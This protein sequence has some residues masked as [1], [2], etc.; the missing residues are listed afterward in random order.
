LKRGLI[1]SRRASSQT[2]QATVAADYPA[3]PWRCERTSKI[4]F[5]DGSIEPSLSRMEFATLQGIKP[6]SRQRHRKYEETP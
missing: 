6:P 2:N 4:T 3:M 5:A 1:D